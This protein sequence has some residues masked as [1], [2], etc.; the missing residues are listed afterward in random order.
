MKISP[1]RLITGISV[2]SRIVVLAVIPLLGFLA[3]GTAFVTGQAE[4]D[5]AFGSVRNAGTLAEASQDL[6]ASFSAMRIVVRDFAAQ[7]STA[8]I[9]GFDD[10][11]RAALN[12]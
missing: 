2:R 1:H 12:S 4:V 9:V 8:L 3:N 10:V 5:E 6:K 7:P 11:H